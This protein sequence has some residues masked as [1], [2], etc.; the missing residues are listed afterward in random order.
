MSKWILSLSAVMLVCSSTAFAGIEEHAPDPQSLDF[1]YLFVDEDFWSVAEEARR[2]SREED[3]G[4]LGV[5]S[6]EEANA[7]L[8]EVFELKWKLA[9]YGLE[10]LTVEEW[11][12]IQDAG[13]IAE[14]Q[15]E[16]EADPTLSNDVNGESNA[17]TASCA[18]ASQARDTDENEEDESRT[19]AI[20]SELM[21]DEGDE[22]SETQAM[23]CNG[24][25]GSSGLVPLFFTLLALIRF[26]PTI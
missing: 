10:Y 13:E 25:A 17:N 1:D 6:Q 2:E 15:G 26:R 22:E 4:P 21:F 18:R 20:E 19:G 23:G 7:A 3:T 5:Q 14:C 11:Q 8:A 24:L 16:A 9:S 12:N